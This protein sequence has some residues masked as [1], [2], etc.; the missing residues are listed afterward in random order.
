MKIRPPMDRGFLVFFSNS[1]WFMASALYG[2]IL[3]VMGLAFPLTE[4]ISDYVPV[5]FFNVSFDTPSVVCGEKITSRWKT[6]KNPD[7]WRRSIMREKQTNC[8]SP[9]A[10]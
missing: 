8:A 2:K 10:L 1:F 7:A 3:V 5:Y 4:V 9:F 6:G